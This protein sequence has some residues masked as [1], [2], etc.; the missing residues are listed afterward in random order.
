M[1]PLTSP[2]IR[3]YS[4]LERPAQTLL[5]VLVALTCVAGAAFMVVTLSPNVF[6]LRNR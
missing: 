5:P 4:P 2:L 3:S 6:V 1:V